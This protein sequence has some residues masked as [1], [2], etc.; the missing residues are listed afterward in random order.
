ML[1]DIPDHSVFLVRRT[2]QLH[3]P[4]TV[5]NVFLIHFKNIRENWESDFKEKELFSFCF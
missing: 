3:F 4:N 2:W 5:C 1:T